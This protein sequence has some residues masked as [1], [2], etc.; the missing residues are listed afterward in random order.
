VKVGLAKEQG[1]ITDSQAM[2]IL[3][4]TSQE[5]TTWSVVYNMSTGGINL[6]MGKDYNDVH[7]FELSME[8]QR[9]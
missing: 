8:S 3:K 1:D 2:D 6:A 5:G 9:R 7:T 4:G